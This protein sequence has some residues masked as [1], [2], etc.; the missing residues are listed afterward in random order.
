MLSRIFIQ[1]FALI[2]KL[3]IDLKNGLQVITGETGAGKSIILGALRL[4]MGERADAK[5]FAKAD[6]KSVV[7]SEFV[8]SDNMRLFFDA[9]DLDFEPQTIIRREIQ[10]GGKSRAFINDVP[11][12][13]DILK[14]LASQLIDIHSQFETSNLFTEEF[15]FG[16]LDGMAK[17]AD[18]LNA[19]QAT[20]ND[21]QRTRKEIV[22]LQ[23]SLLDIN[24]EADYKN[25]LLAELT[26][27]DLDNLDFENL[28]Q[29]LKTQENA[30]QISELLAQSI[31]KLTAEEFG[32]LTNLSDVKSK[33]AKLQELSPE[34]EELS[35]R[36]ETAYLEIKDIST[37][38]ESQSENIEI[39]PTALQELL[40]VINRVNAL[41]LKHQVDD[42]PS[43]IAI[44]DDLSASQHSVENIENQIS[45]KEKQ[46][47]SL[48]SDLESYSQKLTKKRAQFSEKL[49]SKAREIFQ[50]LGLEKAILKIDLSDS[51]SYNQFG[52]NHIQI[53]FQANAGFPLKPIQSAVSGGE[54]S[55]VMLA[56]KKIMAENNALPTLI[57]DEIDTGVSGRIAEE[58][59]KL[60]QEMAQDLQLIVITHL[61]Q[62]AAKGNDNY[63]VVKYDENA[64]TKTTIIKLSDAEKLNEIAQL[65]SGSKITDAAISQA[66]ELIG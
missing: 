35:R 11:V 7:E 60:M 44:R 29:Q 36:L 66:K 34:Y 3:E 15:Q 51:S 1:N 25:F 19:Y 33:I 65:I 6:A 5:S 63:K 47:V 40:M 53:L 20:Y 27:A 59:G 45:E 42:V 56:I 61:A 22:D 55:R 23:A 17:N 41:F 54:R 50:K 2:D 32:I 57:L 58:M 39:N 52:K 10:P 18:I 48:A 38:L 37:D 8:I 31:S 16:I 46:V 12:T 64:I 49:E 28:Q 21:Y 13:L 30:D 62:V 4:I 24:R 43:L 14:Q 9:H 26:E